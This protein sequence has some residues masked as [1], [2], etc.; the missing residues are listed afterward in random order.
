MM[1][2]F[3]WLIGCRF[4]DWG[5]CPR[6]GASAYW[7]K[8]PYSG[9]VIERLWD[10]LPFF[11]RRLA[12]PKCAECKRRMFPWIGRTHSEFHCSASCQQHADDVPF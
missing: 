12:G 1:R 5:H 3:C 4:T 11:L 9:C 8:E 7:H 10:R 2:F 6:C